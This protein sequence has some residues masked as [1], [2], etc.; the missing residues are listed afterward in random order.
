MQFNS[1]A[2]YDN[3]EMLCSTAFAV[4]RRMPRVL[5][6][7]CARLIRVCHDPARVRT[8]TV[9]ATL[10]ATVTV[11]ATVTGALRVTQAPSQ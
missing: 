3:N 5:C 6:P 8:R 4:P 11:T 1:S 9:A 7:R 10:A 2:A